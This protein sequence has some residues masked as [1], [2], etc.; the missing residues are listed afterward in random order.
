MSTIGAALALA[1]LVR[2]LYWRSGEPEPLEVWTTPLPFL[3]LSAAAT[4]MVLVAD[5][6]LKVDVAGEPLNTSHTYNNWRV[7][8]LC[9]KTYSSPLRIDGPTPFATASIQYPVPPCLLFSLFCLLH[10]PCSLSPVRGLPQKCSP[11][12]A[13]SR[14]SQLQAAGWGY[15]GGFHVP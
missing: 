10:S 4:G 8:A 15:H 13:F 1:A 6:F 5:R 11:G 7:Y 12:P 9:P 14:R 3:V 2:S